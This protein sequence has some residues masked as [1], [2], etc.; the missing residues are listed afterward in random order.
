MPTPVRFL[1]GYTQD[2]PW[3]PLGQIGMQDPFFYVEDADDFAPWRPG[4]IAITA[5]GNGSVAPTPGAGGI[6]L[7]TT[8][9]STPA[10]TDIAAIQRPNSDMGFPSP[11]T[12]KAAFLCRV[13]LADV[14]NSQMTVGWLNTTA[15]PFAPTDGVYF[16]KASGSTAITINVLVASSVTATLTIPFV[17]TNATY[18]DLGWYL[19]PR[20]QQILVFAGSNL[21]GYQN[22]NTASLGPVARVTPTAFPTVGLNPTLALQSGTA[23]SKT[24]LADFFCSYLER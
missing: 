20:T 22:Q 8:N 15:T 16:N 21:I 12:K 9:S 2:A 17:P 4:G 24:M 23:T 5:T 3:Q 1:S 11:T 18:F 10:G 7:F 6:V 13:Q 14:T 19:D